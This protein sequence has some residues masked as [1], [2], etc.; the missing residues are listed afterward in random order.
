LDYAEYGG[1]I[2]GPASLAREHG[3]I[4]RI[5][6]AV[7]TQANKFAVQALRYRNVARLVPFAEDGDLR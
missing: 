6:T 1:L 7:A 5:V 4:K 3:R 2:Q